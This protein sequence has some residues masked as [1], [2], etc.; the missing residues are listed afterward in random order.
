MLKDDRLDQLAASHNVAQFVS[1]APGSTPV[2]RHQR[3][4]QQEQRLDGS[5]AAIT[6]LLSVAGS[7]NV[8]AFRPGLTK[9]APFAYGI[10]DTA[11]AVRMVGRRATEGF[12]TIVNETVDV[13]DGGVSGVALGDMVEFAPDDTPRVVEVGDVLAA[14]RR[15]GFDILRTVYGFVP[16]IPLDVDQRVEFSI[17][18]NR[19]GLRRT[20]TLVWEI[21]QV[22]PVQLTPTLIWPNRFSRL[23]GDK[24]FGLLVA[25]AHG[26][27]VPRT[28]VVNRRVA[29]FTFGQDTGSAE[30]WLRT[31]PR[32]QVPGRF[33]TKLGWSDPFSLLAEEDPTG[34]AIVSVL[35]QQ[36]VDAAYSGAS[37]PGIM[38]RADDVQGVA[39]RGDRFMLGV[40]PPVELPGNVVAAVREVSARAREVLGPVRLEWA[41]DHGQVWIL[42]VHLAEAAAK[43]NVLSPGKA[44]Q[45]LRFDPSAG[46]DVLRDL[47]GVAQ[48]SGAGVL[49]TGA[50]GTTSHV[51][52]L[53]RK[54]R[55]PGRVVI[56]PAGPAQH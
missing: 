50:V 44:D 23:L 40:Q 31:S 4:A 41:Y 15:I 25:H 32:E 52:D 37:L 47:I 56:S 9:G 38:P 21:E 12:Y 20:H 46:L 22:D 48:R 49:V 26:F 39:G 16:E 19:T 54:A 45:W 27:P 42:Q 10:V 2:L 6:R 55:V 30:N 34:T 43:R 33:T 24:A 51:G 35:S 13:H 11:E 29:P 1:F 14:S 7:V 8:R 3:I 17:H 36:A 53:L 5:A 28:T 18:P